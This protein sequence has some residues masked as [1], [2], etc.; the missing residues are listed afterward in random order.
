MQ[1]HIV[2]F[3]I[4]FPANY[5]GVIDV[6]Y[7]LKTLHEL[8][9]QIHLH[10][11]EYGREQATALEEYCEQV[12]YYPRQTGALRQLSAKPYITNTR[13]SKALINKLLQ[14]DAPILFE[15]LHCCYYLNDERLKDR[16]KLVRMHNIEWEY[17]YYLAQLERQPLKKL[18][19]ML[20]SW[21]LKRYQRILKYANHVFSISPQDHKRLQSQLLTASA[22]TYLP[23]FHPNQAVRSQIGQG[24]YVLFHGDL[25]V[26]DNEAGALFLIE[27]IYK[28]T[29]MPMPLVVAGLNPT[30]KLQ[31]IIQQ[32]ENVTLRPNLPHAALQQLIFNAHVNVLISFQASGMKLKLLNALFT[33]RFCLVN[34]P[35]VENTGLSELCIIEN[36]ARAIQQ[37]LIR[38]ALLPF[39]TQH[40]SHRK[41]E[42]GENFYNAFNAQKIVAL[43]RDEN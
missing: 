43:L 36:D 30:K 29:K 37:Q 33:G 25:S 12:H 1:L 7:K 20:E 6:F 26:K 10:C 27:R 18:Y 13:R 8:G 14:D 34:A 5:G 15:G 42:L 39:S 41:A 24:N 31:Q 2:S 32:T 38:L 40:L 23:A 21:R 19:F 22:V 9:V 11:F 28:R 35:I 3:N 4:P 16:Q 17:Y